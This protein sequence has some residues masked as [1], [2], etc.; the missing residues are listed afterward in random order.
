MC[1]TE[2]MWCLVLQD[3][4]LLEVVLNYTIKF[5]LTPVS[6]QPCHIVLHD[7]IAVCLGCSPVSIVLSCPDAFA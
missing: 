2:V 4:K 5:L 6:C 3:I 1:V 7:V